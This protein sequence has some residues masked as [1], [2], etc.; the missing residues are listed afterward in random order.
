MD[1]GGLLLIGLLMAIGLVGC[2]VPVIPGVLVIWIAGLV[3]VFNTTGTVRWV[4]LA[5][6]TLLALLGSVAK[7]ILSGRAAIDRGAAGWILMSAIA[8]GIVGAVVLPLF[9][10]IP[11][12]VAGVLIGERARL[13]SWGPAWV[14]TKSVLLSYGIGM[15]LELLSGILMVATWGLGVWLSP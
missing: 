13:G 12:A 1:S 5:V 14:S 11:G 10:F 2:L 6:L 4:V 7:F 15:G 8:G 3:W 9:G